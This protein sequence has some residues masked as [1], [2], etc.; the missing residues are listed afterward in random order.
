MSEE[1]ML[2]FRNNQQ[3]INQSNKN[4]Q[5]GYVRREPMPKLFKKPTKIDPEEEL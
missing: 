3:T 4:S 2:A 1:D 5:S